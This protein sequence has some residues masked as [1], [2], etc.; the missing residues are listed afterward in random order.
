MTYDVE[1]VVLGGGVSRAGAAVPRPVLRA[2]DELRAGSELAREALPA[3]VVQLLPPDADAGAWGAV[4]L[5]R[6]ASAVAT[7]DPRTRRSPDR[8]VVT[9]ARRG[10]ARLSARPGGGDR[11]RHPA[12]PDAGIRRSRRRSEN[13]RQ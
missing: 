3:D 13:D 1:R 7:G 9:V 11:T 5:A 12:I 2:L 4:I 6:S 8:E 10:R